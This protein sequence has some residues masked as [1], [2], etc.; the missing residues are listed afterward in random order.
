[1]KYYIA[2]Q[3]IIDSRDVAVIFGNNPN[4]TEIDLSIDETDFTG[5][6]WARFRGGIYEKIHVDGN[7]HDYSVIE[8]Q[9]PSFRNGFDPYDHSSDKSF[10]DVSVYLVENEDPELEIVERNYKLSDLSH[11]L[12][13]RIKQEAERMYLDWLKTKNH[14]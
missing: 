6:E 13:G 7:Y 11:F 5:V 9:L 8:V 12:Q 2:N 14:D 10:F 3:M 4:P 1:M